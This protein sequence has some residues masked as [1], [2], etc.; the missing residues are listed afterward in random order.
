MVKK[1]YKKRNRKNEGGTM[2][3]LAELEKIRN[4]EKKK[5]NLRDIKH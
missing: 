3:S 5:M 1:I 2:K 4:E